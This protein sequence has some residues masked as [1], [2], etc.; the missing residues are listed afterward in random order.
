VRKKIIMSVEEPHQ[1]ESINPDDE[2]IVTNEPV[3]K[4]AIDV[5][6]KFALTNKLVLKAYGEIIPNAVA[7]ANIITENILKGNSK[8]DKILLDSKITEEEG[9]ISNIQI[10]LLKS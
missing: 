6:S 9:M 3:M 5:I 4:T 1:S 2:L 7:V 10:I 8:I